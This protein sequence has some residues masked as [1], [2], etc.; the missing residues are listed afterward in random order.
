M[1]MSAIDKLNLEREILKKFK[2]FSTDLQDSIE[3]I[4]AWIT[5]EDEASLEKV[6][7]MDDIQELPE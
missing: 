3:G 2:T 6:R 1:Y 5:A 7:E 4:R